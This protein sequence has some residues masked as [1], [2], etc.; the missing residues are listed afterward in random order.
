VCSMKSWISSCW[1]TRWKRCWKSRRCKCK[2]GDMYWWDLCL[3]SFRFCNVSN[4]LLYSCRWKI[5]V[6]NGTFYYYCSVTNKLIFNWNCRG[7][8]TYM[9]AT[10]AVHVQIL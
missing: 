10:D 6:L 1:S 5:L 7:M 4:C 2:D 3:M 9:S 8:W